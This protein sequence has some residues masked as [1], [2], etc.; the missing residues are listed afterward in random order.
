MTHN[1]YTNWLAGFL[2]AMEGQ[3]LTE[4]EINI[5]LNKTKEVDIPTPWTNPVYPPIPAPN[6]SPIDTW[7]PHPG[8]PW[9]E[10]QKLT[11]PFTDI[12]PV[13]KCSISN[14]GDVKYC[15]T[16]EVKITNENSNSLHKFGEGNK[17]NER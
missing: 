14:N 5:I 13:I 1:E 11:S 15:T 9:I 12:P 17:T 10:P 8:N 2:S 7:P 4:R 3:E 16:G 6:T